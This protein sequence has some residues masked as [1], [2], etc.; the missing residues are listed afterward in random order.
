MGK[1]APYT[2]SPRVRDCA[3]KVEK[4]DT[5][6]IYNVVYRRWLPHRWRPSLDSCVVCIDFGCNLGIGE[7]RKKREGQCVDLEVV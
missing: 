3:G 2:I 1:A 7:E 4:K 6:T 5:N